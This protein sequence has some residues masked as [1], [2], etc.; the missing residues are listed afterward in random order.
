MR[1]QSRGDQLGSRLLS[2]TNLISTIVYLCWLTR[3]RRYEVEYLLTVI[4]SDGTIEVSEEDDLRF[5]VESLGKGHLGETLWL[6]MSQ[7]KQ[8]KQRS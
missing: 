6:T 4:H 2:S 7:Q 8:V 5:G 3:G 1:S